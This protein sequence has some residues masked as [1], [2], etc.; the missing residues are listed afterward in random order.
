MLDFKFQLM[1]KVEEFELY[2]N[3]KFN[4]ERTVHRHL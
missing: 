3:L 1:L 2:S 4:Y